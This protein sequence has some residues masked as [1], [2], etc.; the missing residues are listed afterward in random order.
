VYHIYSQV[1]SIQQL[2]SL[3]H[4]FRGRILAIALFPFQNR[5]ILMEIKEISW[6]VF[7]LTEISSLISRLFVMS[8]ERSATSLLKKM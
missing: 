5:I 7:M 4:L 6:G 3:S 8:Q 1:N 2:L